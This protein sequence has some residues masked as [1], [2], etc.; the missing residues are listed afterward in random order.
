MA[1]LKWLLGILSGMLLLL[2]V[3]WG[4]S[5]LSF[6]SPERLVH[7]PLDGKPDFVKTAEHVFEGGSRPFSYS[8]AYVE[9]NNNGDYADHTQVD[10]VLADLKARVAQTDTVILVYV[11]G[12][13]HDARDGDT[14]VACFEELLKATAIMQAT[15]TS[16]IGQTPRGVYGVYIGWP[17]LVY[18]DSRQL[19]TFF[20]RQNAADRVGERGDLLDLFSR[21]SRIRHETVPAK[22]Q[23]PQ[24]KFVIIS[25]SLGARLTYRALRPVMQSSLRD[26]DSRS[27]FLAD[28]AVM[29]NPAL[30]A[31]EH[32]S[33]ERIVE[34][35][36]Q[37]DANRSQPRFVIATSQS[38]TVLQNEY[39]R[40]QRAAGW[41]RGEFKAAADPSVWP[42]GLND[43]YLTHTLKLTGDYTRSPSRTACPT[44]NHEDLEIARG[45]RRVKNE[46][47][48][49]DYR[50]VRHYDEQNRETY[51][52][53][54]ENTGRRTA[55]PLM[56]IKVTPEIIPNHN[57]I[58][59]S[60]FVDFMSR[61]INAGLYGPRDVTRQAE[62]PAGK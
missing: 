53:I 23:S 35:Q 15:Y 40:S 38:D 51:R 44:L 4:A 52:T 6:R 34:R 3:L 56:V 39:V 7:R 46:A 50:T 59:T 30:S 45:K 18:D 20:A 60:P 42:I 28:V 36:S 31:D 29:V 24:T 5:A 22:A 58:F 37:S 48:L 33:L 61:V 43:E 14:N 55:G 41:M 54:L 49:Y 27:P 8:Y 19:F 11:H 62:A 10:R 1:L 17:G 25:H 2:A 32:V 16:K 47:E 13:N 21:I 9:F 57:D 12:W 26:T